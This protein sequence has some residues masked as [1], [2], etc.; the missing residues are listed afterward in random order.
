[1]ISNEKFKY[2]DHLINCKNGIFN[3]H[4]NTFHPHTIENHY[5][6]FGYYPFN[7]LDVDYRRGFKCPLI[8]KFIKEIF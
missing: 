7:Q 1:M 4:E 6:K 5:R 2:Y 8:D 3:M